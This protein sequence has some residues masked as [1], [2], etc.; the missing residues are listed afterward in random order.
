[1][2]LALLE[3]AAESTGGGVLFVAEGTHVDEFVAAAQGLL[4]LFD[5]EGAT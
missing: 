2:S 1:M 5:V 3:D 4:L